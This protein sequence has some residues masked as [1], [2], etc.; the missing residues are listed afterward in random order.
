MVAAEVDVEGLGV[1]AG[2]AD[3]TD[4]DAGGAHVAHVAGEKAAGAGDKAAG[5]L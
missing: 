3:A 5:A 4:D 2:G 1:E